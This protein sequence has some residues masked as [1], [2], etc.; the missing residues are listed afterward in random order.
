MK[1]R[2]QRERKIESMAMVPDPIAIRAKTMVM[3]QTTSAIWNMT[4]E[5]STRLRM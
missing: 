5:R 4:D 1:M 2:M 3:T